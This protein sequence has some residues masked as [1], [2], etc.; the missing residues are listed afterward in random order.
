MS[1]TREIQDKKSNARL[2]PI[3]K[4]ISW[5]LLFYYPIIYLFLIQVKNFSASQ[6]LLADAFFTASCF[7]MQIPLGLLIDKFGKK[8][9]VVFA[10]L[11]L[12]IFNL[13]LMI[14]NTYIQLFMAFFVF[15]VGYVIKGICET[16]ILYD[17][18]PRGEKRGKLYSKIDGIGTSR[19][20]VVDAVTSII[21]GFAFVINPYLPLILC[22]IGNIISTILST[23]FKHTQAINNEDEIKENSKEYFRELK[24]ALKFSFKSKRMLSL[25]IFFGLLSGL[26][27]N[28]GTVRNGVLTQVELPEQYFGLVYA[29]IQVIAAICS[30]MQNV[31][32]KKF[33]NKTLSVL[34]ISTAIV[35]II[36]GVLGTTNIGNIRI[37]IILTLFVLL[38]GIKGAFNVLIFRYLNNFTNRQIRIKLA[39]VR[40]I[41]YNVF[42]IIISLFGAW[43][44]SFTTPSNSIIILGVISIIALILLLHYMK[45]KVGLK[46]EKYSKEDLKYSQ[47]A[48]FYKM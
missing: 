8:N 27:Y 39:I 40:N 10:N 25:L 15:A 29:A 44:L 1:K 26:Y 6:V 11:C 31:I 28:W 7:V 34:G 33:R 46:P 37:A 24:G 36:I 45:D 22:L 19:Y 21:A 30:R 13:V 38:G 17:S 5:D 3:Y 4:M 16:N 42:T 48:K 47:F 20:Y 2:Y 18:L 23:R 14:T 35:I 12:C 9:S 41:I 43:I 32:H